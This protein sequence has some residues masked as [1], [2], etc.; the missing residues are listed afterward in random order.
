[1]PVDPR[2]GEELP[3]TPAHSDF[4]SRQ[5][6]NDPKDAREAPAFKD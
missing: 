6:A 4:R 1:M 5:A 3:Y 2:T